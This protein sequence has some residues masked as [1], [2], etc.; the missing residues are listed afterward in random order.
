MNDE[1]V[2]LVAIGD[3]AGRASL[4]KDISALGYKVRASDDLSIVL[5]MTRKG[6]LSLVVL[7]IDLFDSERNGFDVLQDIGR[8]APK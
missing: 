2:I 1:Q 4:A 3:Q 5:K 7:D 6:Q 8:I